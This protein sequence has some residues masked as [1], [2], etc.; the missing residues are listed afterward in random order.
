MIGIN[1]SSTGYYGHTCAATAPK[2]ID[3]RTAGNQ[4]RVATQEVA[5]SVS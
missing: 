5:F 2:L 4:S 3:F 1:Q